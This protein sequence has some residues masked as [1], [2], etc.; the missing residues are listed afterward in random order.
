[1]EQ[2]HRETQLFHRGNLGINPAED[3][4]PEPQLAMQIDA[5]THAFLGDVTGIVVLGLGRSAAPGPEVFHPGWLQGRDFH[6]ADNL[7]Q[8]D[9]GN[10]VFAEQEVG[11]PEF[12]ACPAEILEIVHEAIMAGIPVS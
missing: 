9:M 12:P 7:S 3:G 11:G 1:M 8:P 2:S 4:A 10:G 5:E 6:G